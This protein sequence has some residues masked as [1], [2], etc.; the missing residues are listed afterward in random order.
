M[1]VKFP[2]LIYRV[3]KRGMAGKLERLVHEFNFRPVRE[4][5]LYLEQQG[6]IKTVIMEEQD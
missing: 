1:S 3:N 4:T 2:L 5:I 6:R